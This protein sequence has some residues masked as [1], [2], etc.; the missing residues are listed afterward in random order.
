MIIAKQGRERRTESRCSNR[1]IHSFIPQLLKVHI[2]VYGRHSHTAIIVV[3]SVVVSI[4][5]AVLISG[6]ASMNKTKAL[7]SW[8]LYYE[9]KYKKQ[10]G[11]KVNLKL[12]I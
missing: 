6:G 8:T 11:L 4:P 1:H 2:I 7:P 9:R 10:D 3:F 5:G 12:S